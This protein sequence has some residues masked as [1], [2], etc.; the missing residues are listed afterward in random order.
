MNQ[1]MYEI[2][3]FEEFMEFL[4]SSDLTPAEMRQVI[5]DALKVYS[6]DFNSSRDQ[7]LSNLQDYWDTWSAY[8]PEV[9]RPLFLEKLNRCVRKPK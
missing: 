2:E 8:P 4:R 7:I 3:T 1:E 6:I 5:G 9:E